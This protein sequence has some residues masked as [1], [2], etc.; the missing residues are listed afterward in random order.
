MKTLFIA[1]CIVFSS[2][3]FAAECTTNARGRTVCGDGQQAV[4]VNP[5]TGNAVKAEKN[6]AG[7]T[8]TESNKGGQAKTKGGKGVYKAP[9]GTT[10]VKG[11]NAQGCN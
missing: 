9:D 5:N 1:A 4:R 10:C 6:E 11:A 8:T 3:A 2:S 7:V